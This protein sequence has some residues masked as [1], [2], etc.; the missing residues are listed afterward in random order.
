M[1]QP[2]SEFGD[3]LSITEIERLFGHKLQRGF[4]IVREIPSPIPRDGARDPRDNN[5]GEPLVSLT[6][7]LTQ[8]VKGK[9]ARR[10]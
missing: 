4:T 5:R 1:H 3:G 8:M 10:A 2:S 6:E 9:D 7:H